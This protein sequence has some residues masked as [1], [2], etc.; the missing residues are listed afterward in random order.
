MR[1][2]LVQLWKSINTRAGFDGCADDKA[3]YLESHFEGSF[4]HYKLVPVE[5]TVE[6]YNAAWDY[7]AAETGDAE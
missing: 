5:C 1:T 4:R 7:S 6:E 2:L 3:I